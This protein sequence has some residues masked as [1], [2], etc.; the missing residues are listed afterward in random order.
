MLF[1]GSISSRHMNNLT[2]SDYKL[3]INICLQL[4]RLPSLS[5][6]QIRDIDNVMLKLYN[7]AFESTKEK[8]ICF[9]KKLNLGRK[10]MATKQTELK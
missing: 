4:L 9:G 1:S 5:K 8:R 10:Q 7:K 2:N 3:L 6:Q